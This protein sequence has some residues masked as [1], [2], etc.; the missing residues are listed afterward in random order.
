MEP[1][2]VAVP[3]GLPEKAMP[4]FRLLT[5]GPT[6][7]PEAT[8]L[9]L[10][11]P[12]PYHRTPE[13][14]Q[15]LAEVLDGLRLVFQTK[16]D[17]V[18]LT[19]SG[20]GAVEAA[21]VCAVPRGGKAICV[22][23]GRF[24][25]RWHKLWQ[26][27]GVES[28]PVTAEWGQAVPTEKVLEALARHPDAQAVLAVHSETSTGVKQDIAAI[29]RAVAQT[30]AVFIVDGVSS[31]GA[32]ECRTDDWRIDLLCT[33]SQKALMA[34]PGLAFV[35]VSRKAWERIDANP[36]LASF[37]FDLRMYRAKL[38]ENDTPFTPAHTLLRALK[39]SLDQIRA[40]GMEQ[41][42]Q[43]HRRLAAAG[44]AGIEAMGLQPFAAV[45]AEGLTTAV[46]PPGIDG[47]RLLKELESQYGLK[48]A[49]GQDQLAGK[50][51]RLAHMGYMDHFDLLAALAGL[52]LVLKELGHRL[53]LGASLAAAQ[54]AFLAT[55]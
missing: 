42:W 17:I 29:G 40:E 25:E 44:R 50:I 45:P 51:I 37:Y 4:K 18:P 48:L 55:R 22:F 2:K 35:S 8:L 10:A 24:G 27:F 20:T 5:P 26:S 1:A 49:G 12:V 41:V 38:A 21:Q 46:V 9:D 28:V 15:L 34:P 39:V 23:A 52:E 36:S 31:V 33:G 53:E 54:R 43:R 32:M 13:A 11:R 19:A 47:K 6:P 7:V 14:K 16:N 30:S 3:N